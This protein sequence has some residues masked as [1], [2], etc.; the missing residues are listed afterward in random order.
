MEDSYSAVL[1]LLRSAGSQTSQESKPERN[2]S[3]AG[4]CLWRTGGP[5]STQG[6]ANTHLQEKHLLELHGSHLL[7]LKAGVVSAE[8]LVVHT[9]DT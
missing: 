1:F 6:P 2:R 5:W 3:L 7:T 9:W 8:T 4:A